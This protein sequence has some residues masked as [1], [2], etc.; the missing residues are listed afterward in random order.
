MSKIFK[1]NSRFD[2]LIAD[3]DIDNKPNGSNNRTEPEKNTDTRFNNFKRDDRPRYEDRRNN[4]YDTKKDTERKAKDD[5][6]RKEMEIERK[7]KETEEALSANNFPE[8]GFTNKAQ[9]VKECKV[10]SFADK[11]KEQMVKNVV[12]DVVETVEEYIS[13]GYVVISRDIA[14]NK[15]IFKFGEQILPLYYEK[16]SSCSDNIFELYEKRTNTYIEMWGEFQYTKVFKFPNYDYDYF[17]RLDLQY[18]EEVERQLEK[19]RETENLSY[20]SSDEY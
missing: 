8:M 19:R 11:I 2:A 18:E 7:T 9:T 17:D 5:Q 3:V 10:S 15:S 16:T 4:F 20:I 6:K 1:T 12:E 14:T 13:P